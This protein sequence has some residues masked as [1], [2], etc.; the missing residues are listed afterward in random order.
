MAIEVKHEPPRP[1]RI[2]QARVSTQRPYSSERDVLMVL[3][4]GHIEGGLYLSIR[5]PLGDIHIG[6]G[7]ARELAKTLM[8]MVDQGG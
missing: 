8:E 1:P 3:H 6:R 5:S 4:S 2:T 7:D